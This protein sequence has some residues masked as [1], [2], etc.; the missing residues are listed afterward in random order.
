MLTVHVFS[1]N[2]DMNAGSIYSQVVWART[3]VELSAVPVTEFL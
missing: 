1:I 2:Q 3:P